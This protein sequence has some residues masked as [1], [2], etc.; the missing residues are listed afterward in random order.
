MHKAY[1]SIGAKPG[2]L[3]FL[4]KDHKKIKDGETLPPLRGVCSAK[5]GPGS[6]FSS[7][8]S[9]I[10]NKASDAENSST[11]CRSTEEAMRRVLE[12][13]REIRERV[14]SGDVDF[15]KRVESLI[16]LSM[17]VN[18]LYPSVEKREATQIIYE[19]LLD[20]LTSGKLSM[21]N[22]DWRE[23]G[24]YLAVMCDS[25]EIKRLK[26]LT[27]IPERT[28]GDN[29]SGRKPGPA[30]WESDIIERKNADGVWEK[31]PKWVFK[32]EPSVHQ[33]NRMLAK[34]ISIAVHTAMS[35]HTYRFDGR[36]FKQEDG[37]PIGDELAQAVARI[38][39]NWWDRRFLNLCSETGVELLMYLRYVDDTNK[40]VIPPPLGTRFIDGE[41]QVV[42]DLID[43]DASL[44]RDKVVGE[45]LRT[46]ANSLSPMLQFEED[47][48][49]NYEDNRL[50]IL[51]L[52]VWV[53]KSA[54][55]VAIRHTFYMKPMASK[56]TLLAKTAFPRSQ[57]RAI[58]VQEVLR[59]LRN[60]DPEASWGERGGHLT[61]FAASM[62]ASGHSEHFRR[63]VFQKAAARFSKELGAHLSGE[64]D[65]YRSRV[66]RERQVEA[67]GGKA[68]KDNWFRK[69]EGGERVTSVLRVPYTPGGEL[70]DRVAK[71]LE[72][73][74]APHG[75]KTKVQEQGG[76]KL[77]FCLT[78]SDPF[79][80]DTCGRH[81]CPITR[82]N[83][84]CKEQCYQA[85]SNYVVLCQRC[86][87]PDEVAVGSTHINEQ[88]TLDV[89]LAED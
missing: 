85:H 79:P 5:N 7:L 46:M 15:Q 75:V 49:S 83:Q 16:A 42:P 11:E 64:A 69:V 37:A 18:A 70:R 17:D 45:L 71:S 3:Y 6:R 77:A 86:D 9:T 28:V 48:A 65:I 30:Y 53:E 55:A 76:S 50:P 80:R 57:I 72:G 88:S 24:K 62:R 19:R 73:I 59:R 35:N 20:L 1:N 67:R 41:L 82:G 40:A 54:Q 52:K 60:C 4:I 12:T 58:M 8:L 2:V 51:D 34:M 68:T 26:L 66:E 43:R 78:K 63:V 61:S 27:V 22:V 21:V 38:V 29:A 36:V 87:P 33:K 23:V 31:V 25:E 39:M 56:M 47:V 10:L 44:P 32:K 84:E 81:T 13:N 14:A 89:P 74:A